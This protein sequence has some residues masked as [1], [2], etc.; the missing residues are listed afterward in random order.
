[1]RKSRDEVEVE[2]WDCGE[3]SDGVTCP[4]KWEVGRGGGVLPLQGGREDED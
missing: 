2:L 3:R 4:G 1:M